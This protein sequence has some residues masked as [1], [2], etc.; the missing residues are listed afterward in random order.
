MG[1]KN[2]GNKSL[3]QPGSL[4]DS[5]ST[6]IINRIVGEQDSDK[7]KDLVDL[8]NANQSK[9]NIVRA[10]IYSKLLDKISKE[11]L[12]RVSDGAPSFTN[13]ELL[14]YLKATTVA[15]EKNSVNTDTI[16]V[17]TIQNNT[18]VN[19]SVGELNRESREKVLDA[20]KA[21]MLKVDKGDKSE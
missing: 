9:K 18:Q 17:P 15:M 6:D 7:L 2:K 21:I 19:I 4:L 20:V 3:S 12:T 10:D 5:A 8:F 1:K 16:N 11:M 14:D 13:E